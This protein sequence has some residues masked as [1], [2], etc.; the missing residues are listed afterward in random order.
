MG[1]EMLSA[2]ADRSPLR[3]VGEGPAARRGCHWSR[4]SVT[5]SR[6]DVIRHSVWLYFRFTLS[7]HD[8][9]EMLTRRRIDVS[10]ETIRCWTITDRKV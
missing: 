8:A 9:E 10:Y 4:S 5:D 3:A 2:N 7:F 6:L 1:W